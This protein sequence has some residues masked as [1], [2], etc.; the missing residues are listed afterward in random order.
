MLG[1]KIRPG[2]LP[3]SDWLSHAGQHR[4]GG[5]FQLLRFSCQLVKCPPNTRSSI[6][7]HRSPLQ[8]YPIHRYR[9]AG[10][11]RVGVLTPI[12]RLHVDKSSLNLPPVFLVVPEKSFGVDT[13]VD[14]GNTDFIRSPHT[15]S[16]ACY[17]FSSCF[18]CVL[19]NNKEGTSVLYPDGGHN[20]CCRLVYHS[21]KTNRCGLPQALAFSPDPTFL[22]QS[23]RSLVRAARSPVSEG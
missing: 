11:S 7:T 22:Y 18:R 3:V 13:R 16:F 6:K 20:Y 15:L 10:S 21:A 17:D 9:H 23:R 5:R 8:W 19:K 2:F 4:F 14:R 12:H 1:A